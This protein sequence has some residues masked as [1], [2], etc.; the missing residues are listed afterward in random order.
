MAIRSWSSATGVTELPTQSVPKPGPG[1]SFA[2]WRARAVR[3]DS[4]DTFVGQGRFVSALRNVASWSSARARGVIGAAAVATVVTGAAQGAAK[5]SSA[6]LR[7]G[8]STANTLAIM[9][10]A[11]TALGRWARVSPS[12][13]RRIAFVSA[14]LL[15]FIILTGAAVRLTGSGLGCVDWPTCNN[16]SVTPELSDA[17]GLIEFGNRVVT[18]LCVFAAGV[19][20]LATLVRV[21]YRRD[22]VRPAVVVVVA[23]M[24]NAVLGGLMVKKTLPPTWVLSHFLLAIA[25]LAA[26]LVLLHR[27]GESSPTPGLLGR[28]RRPAFGSIE[29]WLGRALTASAL[30]TLFLGTIVTGS[31]PHAGDEAAERLGFAM[32]SVARVHSLAAWAALASGLALGWRAWK[33][34]AVASS[35][36][37]RRVQLLLFVIVLQGGVGYLQWFNQVPAGLV[38]IHIIGA[39]GFWMCVLWVRAALTVP[40]IAD[41][42]GLVSGSAR[43]RPATV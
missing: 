5:G 22:L 38:F 6:L 34:P 37:R 1:R 21:P 42:P 15:G 7:Y 16:G 30:L 23:I 36:L 18:G 33:L 19:G 27:S 26:G 35:E 20:V 31:G 10:L 9:A 2:N 24:G 11:I 3:L 13:M 29:Q 41:V 12:T 17:H 28:T 40:P 32:V 43:P 39:V 14:A 25:A 8:F 4:T